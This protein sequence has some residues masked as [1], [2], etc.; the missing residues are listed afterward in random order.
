MIKIAFFDIDGTMI[1]MESKQITEKMLETLRCLQENGIKICIATGRSPLGLPKIEGI[2]FDAYLTYN[3]SYC[4]SGSDVILSHSIEK[5]DVHRIIRN[6]AEINRPVV[7]AGKK[8]MEANGI[9]QNLSDYFAIGKQEL[10]VADD[11]ESLADET[12]YQMMIGCRKEEYAQVL[13]DVRSA[14]ITAWW[15]RAADIIPAGGGKG[16]GVTAVLKY[17]GMDAS[18]AI[19]FGDGTNDIEML[20][21]VGHGVA[22]GN[23]TEDVKETASDV[24]GCVTEDGIYHYCREHKLI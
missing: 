8:R 1:D 16:V 12:T 7:L 23:A 5:G 13:K 18:E 9:D 19:A 20:Q 11:F 14:Q 24:C 22:M 4:Y 6:A 21:A 3:G 17:Y 2:V 10:I 15:D